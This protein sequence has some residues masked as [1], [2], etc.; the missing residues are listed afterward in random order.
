MSR[1]TNAAASTIALAMLLGACDGGTGGSGNGQGAGPAEAPPEVRAE[2]EA[3]IADYFGAA[4]AEE[5]CATVTRGF[6]VMVTE[7]PPPPDPAAPPSD[8][9]PA[10]IED[11]ID[12]DA[13]VLEPDVSVEVEKVVAEQDRAAARVAHPDVPEPYG[14][15]LFEREGQW[16][17]TSDSAVLP[18]FGDLAEEALE[19]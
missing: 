14:V 8:E 4:T 18:G 11:A 3:S 17:I 2:I 7:G 5:V 1:R 15:F 19:T 12:R 10:V 9:C 16:L 13:F 6:E